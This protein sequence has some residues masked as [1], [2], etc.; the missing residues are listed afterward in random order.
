MLRYLKLLGVAA[1]R[2]SLEALNE[3][4]FAHA[5][6][7]PFENVSKL[8]YWKNFGLA[9]VPPLET[10]LDGIE[11][12]HF[13][14]TCYSSNFHLHTLLAILGYEVKLCGAD[15]S[16]PDVHMVNFVS[17]DG[18]EYLVDVGYAAPF[19]SP[20]PRDLA[21]DYVI[22]L[23]RDRYVFKPQDT[24][25]CTRV[26][27]HRDGA[28]THGYLAKP[29][30]KTFDDFNGVIAESFQ[31]DATFMNAILLARFYADRAVVIHN[32]TLLE[33]QG[34]SSRTAS[35]TSLDE[36]L[37]AIEERFGI[38]RDIACIALADI[39]LTRTAWG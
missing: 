30:P 31:P 24:R 38:P 10:F 9:T 29:A 16:N 25:G 17:V 6:H 39:K 5:T 2:P 23:G 34:T 36:L 18:R 33:S 4:S 7:I 1:R 26:E 37:S 27:L 14:G 20:I 21:T 19:L 12:F 32:L 35:L 3:L 22:Q 28:L 8:Y 11:R 15:M 13:G